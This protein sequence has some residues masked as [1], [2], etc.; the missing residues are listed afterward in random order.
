MTLTCPVCDSEI[1]V[2]ESDVSTQCPSCTTH[3]GIMDTRLIENE[4]ET[5]ENH[6]DNR[7]E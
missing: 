2:D 1:E 4:K 5:Y 3:F 7:D 6:T